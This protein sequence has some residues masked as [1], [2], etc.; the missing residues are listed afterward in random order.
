MFIPFLLV[1]FHNFPPFHLQKHKLNKHSIY[2]VI[3]NWC[4]LAFYIATP[5]PTPGWAIQEPSHQLLFLS[6]LSQ[7]PFF[8]FLIND[9]LTK[10][11]TNFFGGSILIYVWLKSNYA[12]WG[13][14]LLM[15]YL[16]KRKGYNL[17]WFL[18]DLIWV[19]LK[20]LKATAVCP[21]L[22]LDWLLLVSFLSL[23]ISFSHCPERI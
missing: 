19:Q 22:V 5:L 9:P 2:A 16:P 11:F 21:W 1:F 6:S 20:C 12:L 13:D 23:F 17:L 18:L 14:S 4:A 7:I 10:E 8:F 3:V 15:F